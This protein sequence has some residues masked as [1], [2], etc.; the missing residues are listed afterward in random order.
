VLLV[1]SEAGR[2]SVSGNLK[3]KKIEKGKWK[4]E[5]RKAKAVR[6]SKSKCE[7]WNERRRSET[8]KWKTANPFSGLSNAC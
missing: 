5:K 4:M 2:R 8:G 1:S 7:I 6:I 3:N